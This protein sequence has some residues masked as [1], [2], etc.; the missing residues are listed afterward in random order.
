MIYVIWKKLPTIQYLF[1]FC[2]CSIQTEVL[3]T[4]KKL[5]KVGHWRWKT[6]NRE[7]SIQNS[8]NKLRLAKIYSNIEN[9]ILLPFILD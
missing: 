7:G 6:S 9:S 4:E 8:P 1:P 2:F 5:D 3:H